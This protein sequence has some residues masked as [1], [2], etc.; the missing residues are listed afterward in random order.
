MSTRS[1]IPSVLATDTTKASAKSSSA[2]SRPTNHYVIVAS[3]N[4][5]QIAIDGGFAQANHGKLSPMKRLRKGDG[6][7][8]YSPKL[9]YQHPEPCQKFTAIGRVLDEEAYQVLQM[10]DFEP[11]RREVEWKE[12]VMQIEIKPMLQDL[13]F[14]KD[15]RRWGMS[16]RRGFFEIAKDD[17]EMIER[18]MLKS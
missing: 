8:F 1:T 4:H 16:V 9:K 15:K 13:D 17:F 7:V 2:S 11:W 18:A 10:E 6:V 5:A 14:V 12:G 3:L